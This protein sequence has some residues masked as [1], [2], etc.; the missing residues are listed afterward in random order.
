MDYVAHV[1]KLKKKKTKQNKT[2]KKKK[3][4]TKKKQKHVNALLHL[5]DAFTFET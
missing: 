3:N 1:R 4:K 5:D 2:K